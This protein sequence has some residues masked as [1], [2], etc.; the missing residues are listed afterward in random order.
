MLFN[1]I[2]FAIFLPIVFLLY[3]ILPH[4]FRW[5]LLLVASYIFYMSW[6]PVY[7]LLILATTAVSYFAAIILEK[8]KT[9]KG[10]KITVA[11]AA[12]I[13]LGILFVF[14]YFDFASNAISDI[15]GIFTTRPEVFSLGLLLPVGISF[16][17]FQT[18]GYIVDVYRGNVPAE[19]H[20]G[21][22]ATFVSFFPQ[23][24][25]GPIERS[26]N[27]IPQL[28]S[29]KKFD[30]R[31]ASYGLKQMCWGFF[32]KVVIADRIAVYVAQVFLTP[33]EFT[34]FSLAAAVVLFT[35]QIY[36]DFSGYSDIAI[37]TAKLM[38]IELTT[39][40]KSPYFSGSLRDFWGRWHI[41]LSTWFKDYVYIPLGGNRKGKVRQSLNIMITFLLSGLWHGA[42][43][44]FVI[45][46][47]IHGAGRVFEEL[48]IPK[49]RDPKK[50]P[51]KI[52]RGAAV[53]L[54][55]VFSWIFF[56]ANSVGDSFYIITHMFEGL[57][58]PLAYIKTGVLALGFDL[59]N[60]VILAVSVVLLTVFDAFSVKNDVIGY[61]TGRKKALRWIIY[62]LFAV[63]MI[64]CLPA[65][66]GT[67]FIYFRF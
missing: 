45:W 51:L 17:T 44:T 64:I 9:A 23:L 14:K 13:A 56:A 63:F 43:W 50:L 16:Y 7:A 59:R 57:S 54:F 46:G 62:I 33:K 36:C 66:H 55:C 18:I 37:G 4:K 29:E 24:V 67:E 3:W 30:E 65:A 12:V 39:N 6:R 26:M 22:Y 38:G 2:Q 49:K 61:I 41:T 8:R 15:I 35:V 32:K 53:F 5:P 47:G 27:L 42:D 58:S 20:F 40:F 34:G 28:R 25:A 31:T 21:I 1:S 10:K 11:V 48:V 19:K 52:L 60:V